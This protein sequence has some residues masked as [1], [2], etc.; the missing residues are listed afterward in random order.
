ME[1][2]VSSFTSQSRYSYLVLVWVVS[3]SVRWFELVIYAEATRSGYVQIVT[4][5]VP[6]CCG[7]C[8]DYKSRG[9]DTGA[10]DRTPGDSMTSSQNTGGQWNSTA[11]GGK[12]KLTNIRGLKEVVQQEE[13][14][15]VDS[16]SL[17]TASHEGKLSIEDLPC[18]SHTL[19][20][21][22]TETSNSSI[23]DV[24]FGETGDASRRSKRGR[25]IKSTV[26]VLPS[27]RRRLD[28][29]LSKPK[30]DDGNASSSVPEQLG[31]AEELA[32]E[33]RGAPV[34]ETPRLGIDPP[35][36]VRAADLEVPGRVSCAVVKTES[37]DANVDSVGSRAGPITGVDKEVQLHGTKF[38][39]SDGISQSLAMKDSSTESSAVVALANV[40]DVS[41]IQV[42]K[43]EEFDASHKGKFGSSKSLY[44]IL[45]KVIAI[46]D[47]HFCMCCSV[48]G[49]KAAGCGC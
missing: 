20:A 39:D 7:L 18:L 38:R 16:K 8:D 45:C 29:G 2:T 22:V 28:A 33:S 17:R 12:K 27:K 46:P 4:P 31:N 44:V 15:L 36:S 3:V 47:I 9:E 11:S 41:M 32:V 21:A 1:H 13:A 43:S 35:A 42:V 30:P 37:N 5:G 6:W 10:T 24:T 19:T 40:P 25:P 26:Q 49:H 14:S 48:G 34:E 23:D